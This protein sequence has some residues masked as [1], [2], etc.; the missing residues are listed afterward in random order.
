MIDTR[1]IIGERSCD[2]QPSRG[3]SGSL[4]PVKNVAQ[5]EEL[6]RDLEG[7]AG[8][9]S[10][11][12]GKSKKETAE[13]RPPQLSTLLDVAV[14][15]Q[16]HPD[17]IGL[18]SLSPEVP[19]LATS[20]MSDKIARLQHFRSVTEIP[21]FGL[22]GERDWRATSVP[23]LPDWIG[24]GLLPCSGQSTCTSTLV[25]TFN[26]GHH[27]LDT[28]RT[29][30]SEGTRGKRCTAVNPNPDEVHGES[31]IFASHAL[32]TS[33]IRP[34]VFADPPLDILACICDP[35]ARLNDSPSCDTASDELHMIEAV[36]SLHAKYVIKPV[37]P[38]DSMH[39]RRHPGFW[40]WL[41]GIRGQMLGRHGDFVVPDDQP[42]IQDGDEGLSAFRSVDVLRAG[43]TQVLH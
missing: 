34:I 30:L 2:E 7:L 29:L 19:V 6:V 24:V 40:Q 23:P 33:D 10:F 13:D 8:S 31:V 35:S 5:L 26:N 16:D 32:T 25:I 36:H 3:Q 18:L 39:L 11:Y 17:S 21:I 28:L 41:L 37:Q 9:S 20:P 1:F 43:E 42:R 14:F 12:H 4:A 15:D 22:H 38:R 27:S